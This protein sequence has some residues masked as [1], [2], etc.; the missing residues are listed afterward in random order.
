MENFKEVEKNIPVKLQ[1]LAALKAH[2]EPQATA[3]DFSEIQ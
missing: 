3:C 2:A 1:F